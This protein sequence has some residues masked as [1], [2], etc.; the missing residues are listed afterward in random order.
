VEGIGQGL[1]KELAPF[2]IKVTAIED[3]NTVVGSMRKR[4]GTFHGT[5]PGDPSKLASV[6]IKPGQTE[7]PPFICPLA[8][9]PSIII[10][11][12]PKKSQEM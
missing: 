6:I 8:Q 4:T 7:N 9:I 2:G 10:K 12:L 11:Y 1:A 3:E 5:Q